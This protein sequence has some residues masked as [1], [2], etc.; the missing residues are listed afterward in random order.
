MTFI[1]A[2]FRFLTAAFALAGTSQTWMF[3]QS[4]NLVYF[5]HQTNLLIA[6]TFIWAGFASILRGVQPPAWLKGGLTLNIIITGLV[7]W[8]VLPPADPATETYIWGMASTTMVH[9]IVPIMASIDFLL[10]DEHRR[11][12]WSYAL[13]WLIYFPVY[14]AFVLVRA[15]VFHAT[16]PASDGSPYPYGF[17]NLDKLGLNQFVINC[18]IYLGL[19]FVLAL[20]IV[21]VDKALPQR[22]PLT[23][24]VANA[25]RFKRSR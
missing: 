9:I 10:F 12:S 3:G 21:I 6:I 7:A 23:G 14:L 5:T 17:I 16:G 24:T 19:F 1:V 4:Q 2:I 22:T 15:L 20:I 11:F 13:T 18:G 8:L 25:P